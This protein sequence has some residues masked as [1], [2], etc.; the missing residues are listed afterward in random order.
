VPW[1]SIISDVDAYHAAKLLIDERGEEAATFAVA[2]ADWL[3]EEGDADG[4]AVWRRVLAAIE[5]L[6]RGRRQ[7]EA[8]N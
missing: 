2:R 6:Q 1:R 4:A 5:E 7:G 3:L 8:V